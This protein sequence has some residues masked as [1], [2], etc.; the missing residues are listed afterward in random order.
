MGRRS[1]AARVAERRASCRAA[2]GSISYLCV[3]AFKAFL[4]PIVAAVVMAAAPSATVRAQAFTTGTLSGI[5]IDQQGGALGGVA[6]VAVHDATGAEYATVTDGGG[7]FR[8][9]NVRAGTF[10]VTAR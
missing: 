9:V 6:I 1:V 8:L 3:S 7:R 10:R 4:P 5:V 2:K